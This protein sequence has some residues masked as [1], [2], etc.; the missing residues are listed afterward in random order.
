MIKAIIFDLDGVLLESAHL[1]TEAFRTLF[2]KWPGKTDDGVE[3]HMEHM[4]ISR[5]VKFRHFY[6]NVLGEPYTEEIGA[7]LSREFSDI[8]LDRILKAPL[9]EGT[10][11]F[12]EKTYGKRLMLIASGTP[13]EELDHIVSCRGM[14]KYFKDPVDNPNAETSQVA[15]LEYGMKL[16]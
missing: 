4:G 6:E 5:Y 8:V 11:T 15:D 7:D 3:F 9:V 2:S 1:K 10:E 14:D 13:Q 12:L 16:S